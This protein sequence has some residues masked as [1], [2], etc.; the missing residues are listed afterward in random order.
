MN[1]LVS[2]LGRALNFDKTLKYKHDISTWLLPF[3][4]RNP[5]RVKFTEGFGAIVGV[6]ARQLNGESVEMIQ[7]PFALTS[8]SLE[9]TVDTEKVA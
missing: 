3:Y 5:E 8:T 9:T 2:E 4:T 7:K 6:I 1:N